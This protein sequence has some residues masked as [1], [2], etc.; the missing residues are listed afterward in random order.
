MWKSYFVYHPNTG[1]IDKDE[2]IKSPLLSIIDVWS[3]INVDIE[4]VSPNEELLDYA[5]SVIL[6]FIST[7]RFLTPASLLMLG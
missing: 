3:Y 4:I 6:G 7:C 2:F 1:C 5:G